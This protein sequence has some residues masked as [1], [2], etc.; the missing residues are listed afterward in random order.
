MNNNKNTDMG[1]R[2]PGKERR[3]WGSKREGGWK[4]SERRRE[5]REVKT[6]REGSSGDGGDSGRRGECARQR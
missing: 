3:V 5:E 4:G 1:E 6:Q 2:C